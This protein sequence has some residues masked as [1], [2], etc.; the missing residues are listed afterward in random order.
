MGKYEKIPDEQLIKKLRAGESDIMDFIMVKYKS[1]VRKKARAMYLLGGEN[2]DLIQEGMI[3]LIKAVRDFDESQGASFFSFAELCVSRQMYTAIE[4]S[5]RKKHL[6]LNSYV[7]L[8]EES[9]TE[10]EGKRL[11]LID[12]IEPEQENNPEALYFGKEYTEALIENLKEN[13]STL[14]NH[15]LYLHLMGTD[16]KTIA[17]L[18]DKSP[19]AIDNALQRIKNKA[20]KMLR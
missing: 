4:A 20:E 5:K 12:T 19:K 14:E 15:V 7:S 3:G 11:A 10:G 8:Y 13:L 2:E 9:E 17:E 6:P 18:L 16:Y 1:M